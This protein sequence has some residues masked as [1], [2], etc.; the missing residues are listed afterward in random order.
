LP[1]ATGCE[2]QAVIIYQ[3][4]SPDK[5]Y[6]IYATIQTIT[7]YSGLDAMPKLHTTIQID[8]PNRLVIARILS[9]VGA[10]VSLEFVREAF[11]GLDEPH[12]YDLIY[13]LRRHEAMVTLDE[14]KV[15]SAFFLDLMNRADQGR[16]MMIVSSEHAVRLRADFYRQW[17]ETRH[18]EICDSLDEAIDYVRGLESQAGSAA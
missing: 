12:R 3:T 16:A 18:I 17:Y 1:C 13:D 14:H 8:K 6:C 11:R 10:V 4:L 7:A 9:D 2:A 5:A 15:Q